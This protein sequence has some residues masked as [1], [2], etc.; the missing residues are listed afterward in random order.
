MRKAARADPWYSTPALLSRLGILVEAIASDG[1]AGTE[2][3]R[4]FPLPERE[5]V[6]TG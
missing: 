3:P 6:A 2:A 5:E 4:L 1:L